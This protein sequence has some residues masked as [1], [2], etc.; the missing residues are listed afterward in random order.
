MVGQEGE[1]ACVIEGVE[2]REGLCSQ[3]VRYKRLLLYNHILTIFMVMINLMLIFDQRGLTTTAPKDG[4]KI[5]QM[6]TSSSSR[7]REGGE[8]AERKGEGGL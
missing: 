8:G 2:T 4:S 1:S 7:V 3:M 6:G 5:Q